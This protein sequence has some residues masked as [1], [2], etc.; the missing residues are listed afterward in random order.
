M[1]VTK[2]SRPWIELQWWHHAVIFLCACAVMVSHRPDAVINAQFWAEDGHVWFADAYNLGWWPA[3][4]QAHTGYFQTVPRLGAAVALLVPLAFAP[5]V[6]NLVAIAILALPV[7]LLLMARSATWGDLR[8]RGLLGGMYLILPNRGEMSYG[9]TES[10]WILALCAFLA[11]VSLPPQTHLAEAVDILVLSLSG[12]TGPFCL[13]LF[14]FALFLAWKGHDRWCWYRVL[15]LAAFSF[16]QA[17]GLLFIDPS[18]RKEAALGATLALFIRILSGDVFIGTL[19]GAN[20]LAGQSNFTWLAILVCVAIAGTVFITIC[21]FKSQLPLRLFLLLSVLIF[22]LGLISP[23]GGVQQGESAW[24]HLA[25][26][27]GVR[28]WFFPS[29][30]F[31]WSLLWGAQ[32]R[33]VALKTASVFLVFAMSFGIVRDWRVPA[34]ENMHLEEEAER[35]AVVPP[36]TTVI[37]P[38]NPQ[39]WNI[40]LIKHQSRW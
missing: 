32:C 40:K 13:I 20:G 3:L 7:S 22:A 4:F 38:E 2:P 36:G 10:Q 6:L 19:F 37:L 35:F 26:A 30:A 5:L 15:M 31:A 1:E 24:V 23:T 17:W 12:L 16:I 8:F 28:Y 25:F 39:G 21:L 18:G 9:I 34:L 14:P 33:S 29:L 11:L 27:Q